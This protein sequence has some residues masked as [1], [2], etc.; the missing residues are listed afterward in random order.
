MKPREPSFQAR[1]PRYRSV[2]PRRPFYF[3]EYI[4][5]RAILLVWLM[6]IFFA[7]NLTA[8]DHQKSIHRDFDEEGRV[9]QVTHPQITTLVPGKTQHYTFSR[10][11]LQKT[12]V[13]DQQSIINNTE[14]RAVHGFPTKVHYS[15]ALGVPSGVAAY[16]YDSLERLSKLQLQAD[17]QTLYKA[18]S[19]DYNVLN[20]TTG[21]QRSDS[22]L[23]TE[24]SFTYNPYNQLATLGIGNQSVN[25]EYDQV[26]NLVSADALNDP[27][28]FKPALEN[29]FHADNVYHQD[30][31]LYDQRGR[32]KEDLDYR[33]RYDESGRIQTIVDR[34]T[35]D[36]V[37]HYLYDANGKRVRTL[38]G[39]EVT[40]YY[41]DH[42]G[43]VISQ[44]A[45]KADGALVE[46]TDFLIH[47]GYAV[48]SIHYDETLE[49]RLEYR[50][51]D[52]MGNPAVRWSGE[53]V[54]YQEYAPFGHQ[55]VDLDGAEHTGAHGFT[56]HEDDFT[57]LTYMSAR[58]YDRLSARFLSPD[59]ARDF[60]L[61]N[62][63]SFNLY[64][65]VHNDPVNAWDPDGQIRRKRRGKIIFEK[66]KRGYIRHGSG[67]I[68]Y[69]WEGH[70]FTDDGREVKAYRFIKGDRGMITD[71]H[72][73]TFCDGK[74]WVDNDQVDTI[75]KG[76]GYT[77]VDKAKRGD[78][79]IYRDAQG[80][81]VHSVTVTAVDENGQPTEVQGLGGV[82]TEVT[83]TSPDTAWETDNFEIYTQNPEQEPD[84]EKET[85]EKTDEDEERLD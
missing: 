13:Y 82:E 6:T 43:K 64:Q 56:G 71:C 24:Y 7:A 70:I 18:E 44:E 77:K 84:D 62:P 80:N 10:S 61:Y 28:L 76:D 15:A 31:W 51:T 26:G 53:R 39:D 73:V 37:A 5:F 78:V 19:F 34:A 79:L 41:H 23:E 33:Y 47:N 85:A 48:A 42:Q 16:E 46:R 2:S 45:L 52:R 1:V 65:Y 35:G 11:G 38:T 30:Q 29:A 67:Q 4:M 25:Y 17:N 60:N 20:N 40:Y 55:M 54:T 36:T 50:F 66:S 12:L 74:F 3:Q 49:T 59:P 81:V 68:A 21:Y 14:F 22:L 58:Y 8:Q 9:S 72:G 83:T 63:K 75:L 32:L 27:T 69:S 57:E